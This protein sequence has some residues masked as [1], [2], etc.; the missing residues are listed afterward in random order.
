MATLGTM[1]VGSWAMMGGKKKVASQIPP[2]NASS[3]DEEDFIQYVTTYMALRNKPLDGM[4][5]SLR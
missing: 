2:I 3:K 4:T 1:F 5:V